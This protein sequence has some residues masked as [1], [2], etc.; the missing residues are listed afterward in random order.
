[1]ELMESLDLNEYNVLELVQDLDFGFK[2]TEFSRRER[3]I[4]ILVEFVLI[5]PEPNTFD[6]LSMFLISKL[7]DRTNIVSVALRGLCFMFIK[8][9]PNEEVITF[10]L[11]PAHLQ[12]M[13]LGFLRYEEVVNCFIILERCILNINLSI[14]KDQILEMILFTLNDVTNLKIL[15]AALVLINV[16]KNNCRAQGINLELSDSGFTTLKSFYPFNAVRVFQDENIDLTKIFI[17]TMSLFNDKFIQILEIAPNHMLSDKIFI[18]IDSFA[19]VHAVYSNIVPDD[20]RNE[21]ERFVD[22]TRNIWSIVIAPLTEAVIKSADLSTYDYPVRLTMLLQMT[23]TIYKLGKFSEFTEFKK[24]LN[25]L[26]FAYQIDSIGSLSKFL[27]IFNYCDQDLFNMHRNN[28][29]QYL[30]DDKT[31]VDE[32]YVEIL[33]DFYRD[34]NFDDTQVVKIVSRVMDND[35]KIET[36][37]ITCP[38]HL[39]VLCELWF[40]EYFEN[41]E[42]FTRMALLVSE[43]SNLFK[44]ITSKRIRAI[45]DAIL[46]SRIYE[47]F[48]D[49]KNDEAKLF[50]RMIKTFLHKNSLVRYIWD[51]FKNLFKIWLTL[52]NFTQPIHP[53]T[54]NILCEIFQQFFHCFM[55][56]TKNSKLLDDLNIQWPIEFDVFDSEAR[57]IVLCFVI[58]RMGK[59]SQIDLLRFMCMNIEPHIA[60]NLIFIIS[61]FVIN[62]ELSPRAVQDVIQ[63][64]C[65]KNQVSIN[66]KLGLLKCFIIRSGSIA[67]SIDFVYTKLG[68]LSKLDSWDDELFK[69]IIPGL[70]DKP[71]SI[72]SYSWSIYIQIVCIHILKLSEDFLELSEGNPQKIVIFFKI[73]DFV[74]VSLLPTNVSLNLPRIWTFLSHVLTMKGP[75]EFNFEL[76]ARDLIKHSTNIGEGADI[77][78]EC[79]VDRLNYLR[80]IKTF[81]SIYL[82]QVLRLIRKIANEESLKKFKYP[83]L[84]VMKHYSSHH[85]RIVRT[86][87]MRGLNEYY[88]SNL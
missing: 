7:D 21:W 39:N 37:K 65:L 30:V 87:A 63:E 68:L 44:F 77:L 74:N 86:E 34:G 71:D 56:N 19:L 80:S 17:K 46:H 15:K 35:L 14:F 38:N 61:N 29:F 45:F 82:L 55:G 81:N 51:S 4:S 75:N 18:R 24:S 32:R 70:N 53:E 78:I 59:V 76:F 73:I 43:I 58:K 67:T 72:S 66:L 13:N 83:I 25:A 27:T 12:K 40:F 64:L 11:N 33:R 31:V 26:R 8:Q 2:S 3:S 88:M 9:I 23:T 10:L 69:Y 5:H 57:L 62:S 48:I 60:N 1:M 41:V 47:N 85:K 42:N 22:I 36:I 16:L 28:V 49:L 79:V 52:S 6:Q 54:T 50:L 84:K 20:F